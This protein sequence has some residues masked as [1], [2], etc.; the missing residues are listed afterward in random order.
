MERETKKLVTKQ[1]TEYEV[2]TYLTAKEFHAYQSAPQAAMTVTARLSEDGRGVQPEFGDI[3][4]PTMTKASEYKLIEIGIV[5][6]AGSS[7]KVLERALDLRRD[8]YEEIVKSLD[9]LASDPK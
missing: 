9:F 8:E 6:L 1:G 7:D 3:D 4:M 2:K 5:S